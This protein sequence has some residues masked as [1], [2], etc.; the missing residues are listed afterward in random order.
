MKRLLTAF[1][2]LPI[3]LYS[4]WS[5]Q[6]YLFFAI[7]AAAILLAVHE[8]FHIAERAGAPPFRAVGY[9]A[10][11][12]AVAAG[13][14]GRPD[15][16]A[17]VLTGLTV[18]VM[19]ATLARVEDKAHILVSAGATVLTVLYVAVLGSYIVALRA[20]P[21]PGRAGELL[22]LFFAIIMMSDTGAY[23]AGRSL[24]RH[25]L[26]PRVSP[27]KTVEGS[28]GGLVA[29]TLAAVACKYIFFPSLPVTDAVALGALMGV[30]GQL[31]D[32]CESLLKRGSNVKDAAS[33]LPGHGGFLDRLDSMLLNAP[34]LYY[35]YT[36]FLA[37]RLA[38]P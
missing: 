26:A 24:G 9:A 27:A 30:V 2:A 38:Q 17:V 36:L 3:L 34:V 37:P 1:V 6:P 35:Y 8:M 18:A 25:K 15:L 28:I 19:L 23:Y 7:A 11:A 16:N 14:L 29:S 4:V 31:G 22:T 12:A 33:I 21:E 5:S 20:L 10:A 13:A 32:L